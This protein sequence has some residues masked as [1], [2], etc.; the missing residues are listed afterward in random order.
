MTSVN[1]LKLTSKTT[2]Q[3]LFKTYTTKYEGRY[4]QVYR[5]LFNITWNPSFIN[6][7]N[8][9]NDFISMGPNMLLDGGGKKITIVDNNFNGLIKIN[10]SVSNF[11]HSPTIININL[12]FTGGSINVREGGIIQQQGQFFTIKNCLSVGDITNAD[13]GGICGRRAGLDY[14]DS[15]KPKIGKVII[16]ACCHIGLV[17]SNGGG[18]TGSFLL[19]NNSLVQN[20]IHIGNIS[21]NSGGGICARL[22]ATTW[23][24][25]TDNLRTILHVNNC[26]SIGNIS[27]LYAGG[28]CGE[29][30]NRDGGKTYINNC[31]HI[32]TISG[33]DSAGVVGRLVNRIA[34]GTDTGDLE[35]NNFFH[36]GNLTGINTSALIGDGPSGDISINNCYA[37]INTNN[38]VTQSFFGDNSTG[39]TAKNVLLQ[40]CYII[41]SGQN[42]ITSD[43]NATLFSVKNIVMDPS[44]SSYFKEPSQIDVSEN[45]S[46]DITDITGKLY[47]FWINPEQN[48]I[49]VSSSLPILKAFTQEPWNDR[50]T[51]YNPNNSELPMLSAFLN[52]PWDFTQ[53]TQADVSPVFLQNVPFLDYYKTPQEIEANQKYDNLSNT[54]KTQLSFLNNIINRVSLNIIKNDFL[55]HFST[56]SENILKKKLIGSGKYSTKNFSMK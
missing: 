8:S 45:L 11:E 38:S 30:L 23:N 19:G 49:P 28:I 44:F 6:G 55:P 37:I 4:Y 51:K 20:C 16:D 29:F 42:G 36:I 3:T 5:L 52:G 54:N 47:D 12:D 18:I 48:W 15:T 10:N 21:G 56:S 14:R 17:N 25:T 43:V 53:Y 32:G 34:A 33:E 35:I 26:Y 24:A 22:C 50:Y 40:D 1:I 9:Y 31:Y 7:L 27:G 13:S 2:N 39:Q 41:G 46:N